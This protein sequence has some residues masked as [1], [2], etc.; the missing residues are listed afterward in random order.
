MMSAAF[1]ADNNKRPKQFGKGRCESVC[2]IVTQLEYS[3][4]WVNMG[5]PR[6][7]MLNQ[8]F[9]FTIERCFIEILFTG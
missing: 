9:F 6:I 7:V 8:I 4:L 3:V 5:L 1:C 2:E